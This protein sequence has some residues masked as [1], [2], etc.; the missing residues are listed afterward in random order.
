M[1]FLIQLVL[2]GLTFRVGYSY[3]YSMPTAPKQVPSLVKVNDL[4]THPGDFQGKYV[5]LSDGS[6]VDPIF[7]G[8]RCFFQIQGRESVETIK[9]VSY[10]LWETQTPTSSGVFLFEVAYSDPKNRL[11]LLREVKF[12]S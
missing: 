4:L 10:R 8:G 9:A 11:L 3:F 6:A 1:K 12:P 5:M 7:I 2:V